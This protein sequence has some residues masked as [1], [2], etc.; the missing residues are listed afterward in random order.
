[1]TNLPNTNTKNFPTI[2]DKRSLVHWTSLSGLWSPYLQQCLTT[3][4]LVPSSWLLGQEGKLSTG[5]AGARLG[6][7]LNY[8]HR[9]KND[10]SRM[11]RALPKRLWP[12]RGSEKEGD[13]GLCKGCLRDRVTWGDRSPWNLDVKVTKVRMQTRHGV[14]LGW[15]SCACLE[16]MPLVRRGPSLKKAAGKSEKSCCR[17][18]CSKGSSKGLVINPTMEVAILHAT[19]SPVPL[20]TRAL[21]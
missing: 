18:K 8:S 9:N 10:Q 3:K 21:P 4:V 6:G 15:H 2:P 7:L 1:M 5:P 13:A 14:S 12:T 20:N 17:P 19:P 11:G 16:D